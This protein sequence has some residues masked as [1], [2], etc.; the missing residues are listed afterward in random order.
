MYRIVNSVN[1]SPR[2]LSDPTPLWNSSA[3]SHIRATA[4]EFL[5]FT[6]LKSVTW[7]AH[8]LGI[9]PSLFPSAEYASMLMAL[10]RISTACSEIPT[11]PGQQ[12]GAA[13][14]CC[15]SS[16]QSFEQP[17]RRPSELTFHATHTL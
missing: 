4:L 9:V 15:I 3:E 6:M 1:L 10:F 14:S 16:E 8:L 5:L 11:L 7:V 2:C 13:Q 17:F 12:S